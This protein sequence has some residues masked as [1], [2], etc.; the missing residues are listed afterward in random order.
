MRYS[1]TL[2]LGLVIY[3]ALPH[4]ALAL[5]NIN[6]GTLDELKTLHGIGDVIG[7]R[8]INARPFSSV[9]DIKRVNGIGDV[10]YEGMK[11]NITVESTSVVTTNIE[12][13]TSSGGGVMTEATK[14]AILGPITGLTITVPELAYVGQLLTF[15][16][17]PSDGTSRTARYRW[18]FGDGITDDYKKP[19]HRYARPGTYVVMVE[20]YY[21]KETKLARKEIEILP[22]A[23]KLEILSSEEVRV[24]NNGSH[25]IDLGRMSLFANSTFTFPKYTILLSGQSLVAKVNNSGSVSLKDGE[26]VVLGVGGGGG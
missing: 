23:L 10:T 2:I 6:T 17:N 18:N 26:G 24:V 7:Q 8:I 12:S 22:L 9:E 20:S 11:N 21:Q 4:G 13:K 16:V 19:S 3:L 25:E 15:D 5:I 1:L 14:P